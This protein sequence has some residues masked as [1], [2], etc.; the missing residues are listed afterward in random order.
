VKITLI[1]AEAVDSLTANFRR[2][3]LAAL[4]LM[5]GVASVVCVLSAGQALEGVIVKEMGSFGRPT[6]LSL[7]ANFR[8]LASTGWTKRPEP[9]TD[10]DREAIAGMTDL[11]SGVSPVRNLKLT[12]RFARRSAVTRILCVSSDYFAMERLDL[13]LGR[14]FNAEDDRALRR[15]A[16]LG[17]SLAE[18]YFG[19]LGGA[20]SLNPIGQLIRVGTYGEVEVVGVL[21]R[22]PPSLLS[23]I[24]SYDTTNNGTLFIPYGAASRFDADRGCYDLLAEAKSEAVVDEAQRAIL[25]RLNARHGLWDGQSKYLIETGKSALGEVKSMTGLV[26]TFVSAVAGLSL[27]VAGIGVMNVMLIAMKE[28][29][30]EIGTRKALGARGAWIG[31]QF[32]FESL[33]VCLSGGFAGVLLATVAA[34]VVSWLS[35]YAARVPAATVPLSC[36]LSTLV[37]VSFGWLP[38]RR[39]AKL[40]P[41]EA[42][43]YE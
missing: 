29:T 11:V 33:I 2:A 34:G 3:A 25:A 16:I 7:Q 15:A 32:L 26:T 9:F 42:L 38:A 1:A 4:G 20:G 39:A 36:L 27:I 12:T 21:K 17:A 41:S 13:A 10:A 8:Y 31:R 40:D 35:P 5:V 23:A 28:R 6:H 19:P 30:R 43:R 14:R 24:E 18:K 22:E 37:A